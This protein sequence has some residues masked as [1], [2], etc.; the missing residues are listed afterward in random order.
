MIRSFESIKHWSLR[1]LIVIPS[2]LFILAG[3]S[4]SVYL[5]YQSGQIEVQALTLR[6]LSEISR[7]I[8][9]RIDNF[10]S[11]PISVVRGNSTMFHQGHFTVEHLKNIELRFFDHLQMYPVRGVFFGD[12]QGRG[13]A[14]FQKDDGSRESRIIEYPPKRKYFDLDEKGNRLTLNKVVDWDPRIRPWYTGAKGRNKAT[15]SPVYTFS[16]GVLGITASQEFYDKTGK[17]GGVVGVDLDLKFISTFLEDIEITPSGQAFLMEPTGWL[18]A[19]SKGEPTSIKKKNGKELIRIQA[20]NSN[21]PVIQQAV[22]QAQQ[23]FGL[24]IR[25]SQPEPL[26]VTM[27]ENTLYIKLSP[28]QDKWGLDLILGVAIPEEDFTA[29]LK[30]GLKTS[31]T[32]FIVFLVLLLMTVSLVVRIVTQPL[33]KMSS[34]A[35]SISEGN[36]HQVLKVEWCHELHLLADAFNTMTACLK[37]TFDALETAKKTAEKANFAK[38]TF[39]ATVSHEI[40]TPMNAIIGLNDLALNH[41]LHPK[42]RDYLRKMRAAS[43]SL[44]RIINDILD[45]SK[46]EAG[47]LDMEQVPFHLIEIFE[48]IGN[49]FRDKIAAKNIEFSLSL[50]SNLL[51]EITGDPLRLEQVLINLVS[52]GLKFTHAGEL[53]VQAKCLEQTDQKICIEFSVKDS[54]IGISSEQQKTLFQ[55]FSQADSSTSRNYG[56]TGLGLAISKQL[57]ELMGGRIG[58]ESEWGKG[59]VFYFNAVFGIGQK[60]FHKSLVLDEDLQGLKALIVDDHD[61]SREI[62]QELLQSFAL[63]VTAVS[64]GKAALLALQQARNTDDPFSLIFVDYRMPEMNGFETSAKIQQET[65]PFQLLPNFSPPTTIPKIVLITAFNDDECQKGVTKFGLDGLIEKPLSRFL[66]FDTIRTLFGKEVSTNFKEQHQSDA[67]QQVHDHILGARILVVDDI[68]LNR[69]VAKELL[70]GIGFLV[71]LASDGRQALQKL[72]RDGPFDA[73]LMDLQM[74]GMDGYETTQRI[75]SNPTHSQ[76]PIIALTAH[77][78]GDIWAECQAAGMTDY[79][80]KP[81]DSVHLCKTLLRWIP[82]RTSSEGEQHQKVMEKKTPSLPTTLPGID[83]PSALQRMNNNIRFFRDMLL[84]FNRD[85]ANVAEKIR[86]YL[87]GN[88]EED[89]TSA[90]I[91]AHTMKGI[92][93]NIS[94]KQLFQ[95]AGDLEN[96]ILQEKQEDWHYLLDRFEQATNQVMQS[97]QTLMAEAEQEAVEE[98]ISGGQRLDDAE[99]KRQIQELYRLLREGHSDA[100][101][102]FASLKPSLR[103]NVMQPEM[104]QLELC[105]KQY[106][107]DRALV[108][109]K[110]IAKSKNISLNGVNGYRPRIAS[111]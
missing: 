86:T 82:T 50:P 7:H 85:F 75:R 72:A 69:K 8:A 49:L 39:L 6:L 110:A 77:A 78:V 71:E 10:M 63:S 2:F 55:S 103:E 52:N 26:L 16:D 33:Q 36:F 91:I 64:S 61:I 74:P 27:G 96:G 95:A 20:Q 83:I 32:I 98:K 104:E 29:H 38:G 43:K 12:E 19:T 108:S 107:F 9:V 18:L 76:L 45:F 109:L 46:I 14:V 73:V 5:S 48:N 97:I 11:I 99:I 106:D 25:L 54:G 94:A 57:V 111:K 30:D 3:G 23:Q 53:V 47:K 66:L 17:F 59:S 88:T 34:V 67:M 51:L 13:A 4:V 90:R 41:D 93:G 31:S 87:E 60:A 70:E 92:A 100:E 65:S 44:L 89:R 58:V 81:I 84:G 42:V 56:G 28:I 68:D 22:L 24:P 1:N 37:Q 79:S 21:N 101:M 40:R 35:H 62:M 102:V 105:L 15:W 80:T